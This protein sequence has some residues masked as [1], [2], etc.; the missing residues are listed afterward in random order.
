MQ[1]IL[2]IGLGTTNRR[3][4]NFE[5]RFCNVEKYRKIKGF[6]A[7]KDNNFLLNKIFIFKKFLSPVNRKISQQSHYKEI[8]NNYYL[9]EFFN[10]N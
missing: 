10:I 8:L 1:K 3:I 7:Y 2:G 9:K 6:L 5:E 4:K